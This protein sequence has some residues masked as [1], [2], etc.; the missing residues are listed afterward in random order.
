MI[1]MDVRLCNGP[2]CL[3]M[4]LPWTLICGALSPFFM[5]LC[6]FILDSDVH[7]SFEGLLGASWF[8]IVHQFLTYRKEQRPIAAFTIGKEAQIMRLSRNLVQCLDR[9]LKESAILLATI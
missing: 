3:R 1:R 6:P 9:L 7:P 8:S 4:F 2:S 5:R